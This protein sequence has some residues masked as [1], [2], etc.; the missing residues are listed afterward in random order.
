MALKKKIGCFAWHYEIYVG[1]RH[2]QIFVNNVNSVNGKFVVS[3]CGQFL[4]KI[5]T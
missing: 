3:G 1:Y 4:N 2:K 5:Y